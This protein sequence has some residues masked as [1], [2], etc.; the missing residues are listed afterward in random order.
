MKTLV[1]IHEDIIDINHIVRIKF[2]SDDISTGG[3][4]TTFKFAEAELKSGEIV[5]MFIGL[6]SPYEDETDESWY[7]RNVALIN[8]MWMA[9]E[10]VFTRSSEVFKVTDYESLEI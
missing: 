2:V 8:R 3:V 9:L 7:K 5:D 10:G 6:D 1:K 4:E